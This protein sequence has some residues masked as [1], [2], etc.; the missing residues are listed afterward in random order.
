MKATNR[1][2]LNYSAS[3]LFIADMERLKK[4][5][6]N[7]DRIKIAKEWLRANDISLA[8]Y[9]DHHQHDFDHYIDCYMLNDFIST[10]IKETK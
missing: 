2:T 10:S 5:G 9:I 4:N 3:Y 1:F 7:D 8:E 6:S